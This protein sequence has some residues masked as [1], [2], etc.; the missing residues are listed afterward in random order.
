MVAVTYVGRPNPLRGGGLEGDGVSAE[1]SP[2][3]N[4]LPADFELGVTASIP[5]S[6]RMTTAAVP[7]VAAADA[8]EAAE[9]RRG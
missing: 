2:N 5:A 6:A 7:G 9:V 1:R 3:G 8:A 4:P